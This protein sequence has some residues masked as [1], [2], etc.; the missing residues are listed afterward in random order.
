MPYGHKR[1]HSSLKSEITN[2][3]EKELKGEIQLKRQITYFSISGALTNTTGSSKSFTVIAQGNVSTS[4]QDDRIGA[5]IHAKTLRLR[6]QL[7]SN[8]TVIE[9]ATATSVDVLPTVRIIIYTWVP[10]LALS[11]VP[12]GSILDLG[13]I[14]GAG[15]EITA[16][17]LQQRGNSQYY[18]HSDRVHALTPFRTAVAPSAVG[19]VFDAYPYRVYIDETLNLDHI[20]DYGTNTS[21]SAAIGNVGMLIFSDQIDAAKTPLITG[22]AALY[23]T[24]A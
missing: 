21:G 12:Q 22:Q 5:Q 6:A 17:H 8:P 19:A 9:G 1:H 24:D 18:I 16:P 20:V 23:Y 10:L 15:Y 14:P 4:L 2:I 7:Y 13:D 3:V 11:S